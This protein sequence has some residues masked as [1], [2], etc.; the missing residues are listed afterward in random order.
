[1][2]GGAHRYCSDHGLDPSTTYIFLD[3]M[4]CNLHQPIV[5]ERDI[6]TLKVNGLHM[7]RH[8]ST[9]MRIWKRLNYG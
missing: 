7:K 3:L 1:L 2:C 9:C 8:Y 5:T 6:G 4:C